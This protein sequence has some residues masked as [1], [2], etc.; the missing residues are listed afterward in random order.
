M[1][2]HLPMPPH[3]ELSQCI[4]YDPHIGVGIWLVSPAN[5]VLAGSVA[6]FVSD[7]YWRICFKNKLY[8]AHR[9]FWFLHTHQDPGPLTVDHIDRNEFNNKFSNLRLATQEQQNR[10]QDKRSNNKTGHKGVHWCKRKKK[11]QARI[12]HDGKNIYIGSYSILE[13][14]VAARKSKELEFYG[15]FSPLHQSNND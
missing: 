2:N 15:E 1:A 9:V 3:D 11:Y 8:L 14:A 12:S 7:R 5:G 13:E 6:G 4:K 10:N